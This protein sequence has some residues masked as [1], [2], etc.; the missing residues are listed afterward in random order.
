MRAVAV[1]TALLLSAAS[2]T[3]APLRLEVV[4]ATVTE[5]VQGSPR[6]EP[7]GLTITLSAESAAAFGEFTAANIGKTVE[8]RLDGKPVLTAVVR[9]AITGGR[10]RIGGNFDRNE[11]KDIA[12]RVPISGAIMEAE[13]IAP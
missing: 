2:A 10:V 12:N 9:E 4:N 6:G 11:L 7:A 13:V 3:A 1:M 5:V 8:L